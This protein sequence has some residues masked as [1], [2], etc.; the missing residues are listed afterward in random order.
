MSDPTKTELQCLQQATLPREAVVSPA[1]DDTSALRA[2]FLRVGELTE[3][4]ND[5]FDPGLF[6]ARL[7]ASLPQAVEPAVIPARRPSRPW[8]LPASVAGGVAA[9]AVIFLLC[10]SFFQTEI[11]EVSP[12]LAHHNFSAKEPSPGVASDEPTP[13]KSVAPWPDVVDDQLARVERRVDYVGFFPTSSSEL[14]IL[15]DRLRE[16]RD[17]LNHSSL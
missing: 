1:Q 4:A 16:V 10:Q 12:P 15:Q 8:L 11:G 13:F 7:Q 5:D 17:D 9:A 3:R 14:S 2:A 6:L